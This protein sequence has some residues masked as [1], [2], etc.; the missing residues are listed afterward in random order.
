M[1]S[2]CPYCFHLFHHLGIASHRKHC[3]YRPKPKRFYTQSEQERGSRRIYYVCDSTAKGLGFDGAIVAGDTTDERTAERWAAKL[4]AGETIKAR[5]LT[6][7]YRRPPFC[8]PGDPDAIQSPAS[9]T[10]RR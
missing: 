7:R 4:N 3:K 9:G 10:G 6:S 2:E 5:Y 1:M 8:A